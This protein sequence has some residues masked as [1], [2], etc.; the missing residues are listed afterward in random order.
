MND[1][2]IERCPAGDL[3]EILRNFE[4]FWADRDPLRYPPRHSH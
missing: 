1:V 4:R 2:T 3:A